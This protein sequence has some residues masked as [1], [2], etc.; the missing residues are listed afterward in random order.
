MGLFDYS[1]PEIALAAGLLS[2]RGNLG[3]IMGRSLMDAQRAYLATSED[4]RRNKQAEMQEQQMRMALEQAEQARA[5]QKAIQDA[6]RQSLMSPST[7]ALQ[8]G[9]GPTIANLANMPKGPQFD[10][11]GFINRLFGVDPLLALQQKQ[12]LAKQGPKFEKLGPDETGGFFE[13]G[14]WNEVARGVSKSEKDNAFVQLMKAAGIDPASDVGKQLLVKRLE[15][16]ATHQPAAQQIN[17]GNN[18][19][20]VQ[21][22]D[23]TI[24]LLQLGNRA[25]APPKVVVNPL[26]GKPAVQPKPAPS[27]ATQ[28]DIAENNVALGQIEAA[29]KLLEKNPG[30]VGLQNYA[31]DAVMQRLDPAGVETRAAIADIGSK[32]IHDRSGANVTISEA[33]RLKPFIPLA[34]DTDK[35]AAIKLKRFREEYKAMNSALAGGASIADA[36]KQTSP[37]RTDAPTGFRI[38]EE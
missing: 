33:P 9:Q 26:T 7:V 24:T 20:P 3:G 6:A 28:K 5:Q 38:L 8:N 21:N 11:E 18:T 29:I 30:A 4:K 23:G 13:G 31:G 34:T 2:G 32:K 25:D 35:A 17:Y 19:V 37:K 14:K 27:A 10:Q 12:A 15:K 1:D 16:E 36:I 22:P